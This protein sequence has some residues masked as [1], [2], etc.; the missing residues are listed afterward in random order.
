MSQASIFI[1]RN[2]DR[3][4]FMLNTLASGI[5]CNRH[6]CPPFACLNE[7]CRFYF[8]ERL[9]KQMSTLYE[10]RFRQTRIKRMNKS[11]TV[12]VVISLLNWCKSIEGYVSANIYVAPFREVSIIISQHSNQLQTIYVYI[13][14]TLLFQTF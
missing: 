1:A 8:V 6:P 9:K 5:K 4:Q 13:L 3:W 7:D 10:H 14:A 12:L 11:T 2:G